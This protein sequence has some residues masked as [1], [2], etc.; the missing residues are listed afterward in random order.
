MRSTRRCA[1]W[2]INRTANF[3]IVVADDGSRPDTARVVE[4]WKSRLP[5]PLKHVR[6][7]HRGFRGGEIRNR[8]IR[9]SSGE[10]CI[11][12]DGDCLASADF[13]AAHR[14]LHEPG[15]FV[16]GNRILL[17]RE[18][19]EAVLAQGL[20]AETWNFGALLRERLRGGV[21]R[22]MPTLRLPLGP[23]R[24]L[25]RDKLGRRADLQS[26]G[27]ARRSRSHR[28]FR[29]RLYRLGTGGFRS[30]RAAPACRCAAQG[31]PLRDRRV[32]SVASAKR[33]LAIARQS[34]AARRGHRRHARARIAWP[35]SAWRRRRRAAAQK[36]PR[37]RRNDASFN[38]PAPACS[39]CRVTPARRRT[40]D[41]AAYPQ[42]EARI[43]A[44]L[45][46]RTGLCRDRRNFDR[47]S[48]S[49]RSPHAAAAPGHWRNACADAAAVQTLRSRAVDADRRPA[50]FARWP[51]PGGKAPG[52]CKR[53]DLA[54]PS[55]ALRSAAP[56]SAT[57]LGIAFSKFCALPKCSAFLRMPRS[58][59]RRADRARRS[60]RR[61]P[62]PSCMPRRCSPTSAGP[63]TAGASSPRRCA[64]AGCNRGHR[65]RDRS[66]LSR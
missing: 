18:L 58:S 1:R 44:G 47:Q 45:D 59:A 2:R 50:D 32:A 22:L 34:G 53:T 30:R 42:R 15:W 57:A 7:E 12:L 9:A 26:R 51:L 13:V 48:R 56:M 33:P 11:F 8:G 38:C 16:T 25:N 17:S 54:P 66:R 5:M 35:V 63:L 61:K 43:S 27:G 62:M 64:S 65:R 28:R 49:L 60:R 36:A 10:I 41:D 19:T 20:A 14:R 21:N 31:R 46:R 6:H 55:S 39:R 3:E 40:A 23:L 37:W 4:S 24:K 52:R 29:L